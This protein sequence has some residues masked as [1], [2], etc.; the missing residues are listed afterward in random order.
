MR[1]NADL[2]RNVAEAAARVDA[3]L[4]HVSTDHLFAGTRSFYREDEAAEPLN[5]YAR[6]KLAAE[7]LVTAACPAALIVR[8][9]F[10]GWG[11]AGRQ[12]FSDWIYYNLAAGKALTLFDDVFVTPVLADALASASHR[13][14]ELGATG[15]YNVAGDERVSKHAF[16]VALAAL[17]G[18]PESLIQRG[19]I[20]ASKL[21]ARR[22]HDMSLDN[23]KACERL[24]TSLGTLSD[25]LGAL[26]QQ[27][28]AGR[29]GE[30][31]AAIQE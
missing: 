10:F 16:A 22:P 21:S 9:N 20:A 18:L 12:S 25:H 15:I 14:L 28:R 5:A 31:A 27:D 30:L 3:R 29:R 11:H 7:A 6:S 1:V 26:Q 4:V 13:L 8:T 19:K 24:G 17:Y 2:S 23:R